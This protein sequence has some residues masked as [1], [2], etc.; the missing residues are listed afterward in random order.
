ME[1]RIN[2]ITMDAQ[3]YNAAETPGK[4]S[5]CGCINGPGNSDNKYFTSSRM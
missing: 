3:T 5:I 1:L 4:Y 2:S